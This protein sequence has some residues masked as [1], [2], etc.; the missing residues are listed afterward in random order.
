MTNNVGIWMDH[1]KAVVVRLTGAGEDMVQIECESETPDWQPGEQRVTKSYTP[2][3]IVA[4]NERKQKAMI[5]LNKYCDEV[6]IWLRD[7]ETILVV[8]PDDAKG[9]LI[10]RMVSKQLNGRIAQVETVGKMTDREIVAHVRERFGVGS[11]PT[12]STHER[13]L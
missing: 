11:Q 12:R 3:D 8:G 4:D 7:A 9:E 5:R 2:N 6:I 10:N 1:R 13:R